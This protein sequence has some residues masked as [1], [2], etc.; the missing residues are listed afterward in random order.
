MTGA[1]SSSSP[2]RLLPPAT[3]VS[4]ENR[5]EATGVV[6]SSP[7]SISLLRPRMPTSEVSRGVGYPALRQTPYVALVVP[8]YGGDI[9]TVRCRRTW[10]RLSGMLTGPIRGVGCT[11]VWGDYVKYREMK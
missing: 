10:R 9:V 7:P 8:A 1:S 5:E 3:V 11:G 2:S 4:P 6:R